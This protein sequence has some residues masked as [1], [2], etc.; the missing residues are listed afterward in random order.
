L[1][2]W[3][4]LLH[5]IIEIGKRKYDGNMCR[6]GALLLPIIIRLFYV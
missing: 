5:F 3:V 4:P 6:G 1:E 2:W